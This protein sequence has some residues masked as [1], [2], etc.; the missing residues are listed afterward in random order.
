[1]KQALIRNLVLVI[2]VVTMLV[3]TIV[4]TLPSQG[5]NPDYSTIHTATA[6]SITR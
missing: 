2:T 6:E 1:M 3:L 4:G 5:A